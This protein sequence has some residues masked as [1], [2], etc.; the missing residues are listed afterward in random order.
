[1]EVIRFYP[2]VQGD[3]L[4][5]LVAQEFRRSGKSELQPE[6]FDVQ[7]GL[8]KTG[9]RYGNK[10]PVKSYFVSKM[11]SGKV[12]IFIFPHL[13]E[14][15]LAFPLFEDIIVKSHPQAETIKSDC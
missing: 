15:K 1:M 2:K 7:K 9:I 3:E 11:F 13:L 8:H 10:I 12:S 14:W 6:Y 4:F 5:Y